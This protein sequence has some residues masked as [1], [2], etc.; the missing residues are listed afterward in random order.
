VGRRYRL[1]HPGRGRGQFGAVE[2]NRL[3]V[4]GGPT[5]HPVLLEVQIESLTGEGIYG[6]DHRGE[7][8]VGRGQHRR[9]GAEGAGDMP[10]YGGEGLAPSERGG[11]VYVRR[12]VQIAESEPGLGSPERLKLIGGPEGLATPSPSSP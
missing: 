7:W 1:Q 8:V 5:L 10:G 2:A 11:P 3:D 4:V 9:A 12:E 6:V